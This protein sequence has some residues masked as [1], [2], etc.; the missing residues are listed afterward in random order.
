MKRSG[1]TVVFA[2]MSHSIESMLRNQRVIKEGDVVIPSL[3]DALEWC[4]EQVLH[5]FITHSSPMRSEFMDL[6]RNPS[7]YSMAHKQR[8]E[9]ST[10]RGAGRSDSWGEDEGLPAFSGATTGNFYKGNSSQGAMTAIEGESRKYFVL[11][12]K[13]LL[14]CLSHSSSLG[15]DTVLACS[16]LRVFHSAAVR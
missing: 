14:T 13:A 12:F 10:L 9:Q 15:A 11:A 1:V 3:D 2:H 6:K 8:Q 5:G 16:R 4:E 7:Y